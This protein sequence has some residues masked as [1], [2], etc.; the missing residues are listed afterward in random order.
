MK[1]KTKFGR[2]AAGD[3]VD[4]SPSDRAKSSARYDFIRYPRFGKVEGSS[5]SVAG[6]LAVETGPKD[7]DP[8]TA[9]KVP[10]LFSLPEHRAGTPW[11]RR[12]GSYL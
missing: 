7:H 1:I 11:T 2:S 9:R 12:K 5:A 10:R 6:S 4:T 3:G 8:R